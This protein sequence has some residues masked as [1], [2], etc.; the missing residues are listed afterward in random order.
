MAVLVCAGL[1]ATGCAATASGG[2]SAGP[3]GAASAGPASAAAH[4]QATA[5]GAA[6]GSG[7]APGQAAG[8]SRPRAAGAGPAAGGTGRPLP[9]QQL[10][11]VTAAG[12]GGTYAT[13]TAWQW[14]G[15]RWQRMLGPWTTRIGRAGMAPPGGK[16]EGDGRTPSGTFT[17]PFL[18]GTGPDPGFALRYRRSQSWIAWDDDPASPRYNEWVDTRY[19]D[20]GAS[21][22]PMADPAYVYGAVIGYNQARVPGLGSAIFLHASIGTATAGCVTLPVPE[23]LR[24]LRW[25]DPRRS[26][27]I[28]MGVR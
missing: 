28:R 10:I 2:T 21:P 24:V 25:L 22:E 26:P 6:G 23:L 27:L 13:L 12:Y 17:L 11:T 3:A 1:I 19:A 20:P 8:A 5:A 16:R 14:A 15:D 9:G 4:G 7:A 18:F